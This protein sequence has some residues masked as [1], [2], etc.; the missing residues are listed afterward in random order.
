MQTRSGAQPTT[1][2]SVGNRVRLTVIA[3]LVAALTAVTTNVA[4]NALPESW[5]PY[6]W[7]AWPLLA[8]LLTGGLTL[9]VFA[10]RVDEAPPPGS[11][12][13]TAYYRRALIARP[14]VSPDRG[15]A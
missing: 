8:V 13:R 11:T 2:S 1:M 10:S 4:T 14:A 12:E 3:E 7:L 15:R 6:L 9:A 5:R